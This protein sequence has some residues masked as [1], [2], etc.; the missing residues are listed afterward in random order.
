MVI[1]WLMSVLSDWKGVCVLSGWQGMGVLLDN[2]SNGLNGLD[3]RGSGQNF[4]FQWFAANSGKEASVLISAVVD[5]SPESVS[6]N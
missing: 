3:N 6:V 4:V 2:W 5:R 1:G